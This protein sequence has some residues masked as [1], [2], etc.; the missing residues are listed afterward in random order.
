MEIPSVKPVKS[1]PLEPG[2]KLATI[3]LEKVVVTLRH[4]T[5][6]AHFP[7]GG[8]DDVDT[9]NCN[10]K[11]PSRSF[12]EWGSGR[13]N[14]GSTDDEYDGVF[15]DA[16][17]DAGIPVVGDP[18]IMF[19]RGKERSKAVF[20]IGA[21]INEIRGNV[22]DEGHWYDGRPMGRFSG[23][24]YNKVEWSIYSNVLQRTVARFETE[25]YVIRKMATS[26]GIDV[27]R[28]A[29]FANAADALAA[30]KDFRDILTLRQPQ[31]QR[32]VDAGKNRLA[33]LLIRDIPLS[34]KPVRRR[35]HQIITATVTIVAG[36]GHGSGFVVSRAGYILTNFHVV[37][38]SKEVV[39]V[40]S[41]GIKVTG[42]VLRRDPIR[43]IA[44]VRIDA[45][46]IRPFPIRTEPP[47][48]IFDTVYAVG[49]PIDRGLKATI[50]KGI[51][52]AFRV[53]KPNHL[54]FIQSSV[55]IS[56]GNSGGPL[57]DAFGNVV[58]VSVSGY[59]PGDYSSGLNMFI[60]IDEA[61]AALNIEKRKPKKKKKAARK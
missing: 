37:Q 16:M 54:N 47:L 6:I 21:R 11:Y 10:F 9:I 2:R 17:N 59:G 18:R 53:T 56:G 32:D 38:N 8:M 42:K 60:P 50:T 23:E 29:A 55:D 1:V 58:G 30:R 26:K 40:F 61:L 14:V 41:N 46:G 33:K 3:G 49:T 48:E 44:L 19:D 36:G 27:L 13:A 24:F 12:V 31:P 34:R 35:V 22:C 51:V 25:G 7:G 28:V 39:V 57:I 43:D 45:R 4:G 52:S 20:S 5:V 15:Y